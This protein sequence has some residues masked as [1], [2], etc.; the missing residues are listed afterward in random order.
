MQYWSNKSRNEQCRMSLRITRDNCFKIASILDLTST[1]RVYHRPSKRNVQPS[2]SSFAACPWNT[3]SSPN[4]FF[5]RQSS[6]PVSGWMRKLWRLENRPRAHGGL[7]HSLRRGPLLPVSDVM[8]LPFSHN[9][10]ISLHHIKGTPANNALNNRTSCKEWCDL[11]LCRQY[12]I[13][14]WTRSWE[15][16]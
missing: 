15:R 14:R 5:S 6:V 1:T 10:E 11:M 3:K 8:L 2:H 13:N 9:L 4:F 7:I 16:A 12:Q